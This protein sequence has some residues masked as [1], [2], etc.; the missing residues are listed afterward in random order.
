MTLTRKRAKELKRLKSAAS[1]LWDD[2]K[3]LF[4]HASTVV[5]EASR[6]AANAGREE[7]APRVREAIDNNVRPAIHSG[8]AAS[9]S[10]AETA[11]ARWQRDVLP[12]VSSRLSSAL[13]V[14]E[15]SKDPRVMDAIARVRDAGTQ[16]GMK[17]GIVQKKKTGPGRYIVAGFAFIGLIAVSYA[18]WQT[19]RA[20]DELWVSDDDADLA[21]PTTEPAR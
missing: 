1:D 5:R 17:V 12:T 3:D 6:Q 2:Q 4:E 7:V 13:A 15:V 19:L 20:D 16:A 10:A 18:A 21:L 11:R 9:R 14:L 8:L